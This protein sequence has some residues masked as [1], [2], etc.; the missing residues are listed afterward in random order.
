MHSLQSK[1]TNK[2][3]I[4][5]LTRL[6]LLQSAV[7]FGLVLLRPVLAGYGP[8]ENFGVAQLASQRMPPY[9]FLPWNLF[10]AWVPYAFAHQLLP[11]RGFPAANGALLVL[12]LLFFPN[13]PYIITDFLHLRPRPPIP[14]WYDTLM[15]FSFAWTGLLLGFCSLMEVQAFAEHQWNKKWAQLGAA[16]AI[17]LGSF[18]VYMG[19]FLRWNSWD[20]FIRP[21]DVLYSVMQLAYDP[22]LNLGSVL[23]MAAMLGLG[24]ATFLQIAKK[25]LS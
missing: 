5:K 6:L 25:Q 8:G 13:A 9:L 21:L 7:G 20:A 3:H 19:R 17:L 12:W 16:L 10:L 18:G 14:V 4:S 1:T 22:K 2:M 23:V 11:G 15:L 24:Y